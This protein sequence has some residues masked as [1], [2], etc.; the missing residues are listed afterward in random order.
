MCVVGTQEGAVLTL[1]IKQHVFH[2]LDTPLK[3][4]V[5]PG[6]PEKEEEEKTVRNGYFSDK[7]YFLL[8]FQL[9]LSLSFLKYLS[10]DSLIL[11]DSGV[12]CLTPLHAHSPETFPQSL[13]SSLRSHLH[14]IR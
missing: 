14:M 4:P 11:S 12:F 7:K 5:A 10:L 1:S 2:F 3:L 13:S 6:R 8:Y 9:I